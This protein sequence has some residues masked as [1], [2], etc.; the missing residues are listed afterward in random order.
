MK[1]PEGWPTEKMIEAGVL[2]MLG[3]SFDKMIPVN[4]SVIGIFKAMLAAAP[5]PP[6]KDHYL[7]VAGWLDGHKFIGTPEEA[8]KI[9]GAV[10]VYTS[11]KESA[12]QPSRNK[13]PVGCSDGY[14]T[15]IAPERP[16]QTQ[17]AQDEPVAWICERRDGA[18]RISLFESAVS[19]LRSHGWKCN[20]LYDH[21]PANDKLRKAAEGMVSYFYDGSEPDI[22]KFAALI[23][24]LRAALEQSG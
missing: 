19:E 23:N 17:P 10:P 11:H 9:P 24:N 4:E 8:A 7:L 18:V 16:Y 21:P 22:P 15:R 6:E 1:I 14:G 2:E 20:E 5:T 12:T 13:P 3:R